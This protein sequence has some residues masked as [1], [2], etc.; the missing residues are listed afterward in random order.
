MSSELSP[1]SG[2]FSFVSGGLVR[3]MAPARMLA[4]SASREQQR[5]SSENRGLSQLREAAS[6]RG[7]VK[8]MLPPA[9]HEPASELWIDLKLAHQ[10]LR[11][12][13]DR[14]EPSFHDNTVDIVLRELC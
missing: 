2:E 10:G 1:S 8:T 13:V 14:A 9:H 4:S 5:N 11:K 6:T 3:A 12:R 7:V